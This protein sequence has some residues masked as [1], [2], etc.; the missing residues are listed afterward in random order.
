MSGQSSS[1]LPPD[2]CRLTGSKPA[3]TRHQRLKATCQPKGCLLEGQPAG[4]GFTGA[5]KRAR[6]A[7][8]QANPTANMLVGGPGLVL[9]P[10]EAGRYDHPMRALRHVI[11]RA[12]TLVASAA[13][14]VS[15]AAAVTVLPAGPP[16]S[17]AARA[18]VAS[19]EIGRASC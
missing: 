7:A 2:R 3:P 8:G 13:M 11:T 9:A 4:D 14:V 15:G 17:A 1:L 16:A 19:R 6:C 12:A 10:H 18:A 5:R